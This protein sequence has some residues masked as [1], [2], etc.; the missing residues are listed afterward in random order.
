MPFFYVIFIVRPQIFNN[1]SRFIAG[2]AIILFITFIHTQ[3]A[4]AQYAGGDG[5]SDRPFLI[6]S[7]A[8]LNTIGTDPNNWDKH[9]ILTN[10]IDLTDVSFNVIGNNINR[11]IGVFDGNGK[12]ISH[13]THN[14][15]GMNYVGIFGYVYGSSSLIKDVG[16]IDPNLDAG[17]GSSVGA[18]VGRLAGGTLSGCYV[19]GGQVN[20]YDNVGGLVGYNKASISQSY[21]TAAVTGHN[22]IGGLL[23]YNY[24]GTVLQCWSTSLIEGNDNVGGLVGYNFS[25]DS[26]A[27]INQSYAAGT[28]SSTGSN[29]GGLAGFS[30]F[31]RVINCYS[32]TEV[33]GN[34]AVGGLVG[35]NYYSE[36]SN[37]FSA[38]EVAGNTDSGG[39]IGKTDNGTVGHSFWDTT[40]A[41][42]PSSA[43][44]VGKSTTQMHTETT[45]T[46]ESW[47]FV[48]ENANGT[49]DI[50]T[51]YDGVTYP[52]L[53]WQ[54]AAGDFTLDSEIN[55]D[56][57]AILAAAWLIVEGETSWNG[58]CDLQKNGV[59][60][61]AD[62]EIFMQN[63]LSTTP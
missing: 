61:L 44:G 49:D 57:F 2:F 40:A 54:F 26:S 8:Q 18:L 41:G 3:S 47:D 23:G 52:G 25:I 19:N 46:A 62:L 51:I 21:S 45:F 31:S 36:V 32:L 42:Q 12:T 10:N 22:N 11:F 43:G 53:A 39:L 7:P 63:Y 5:S 55:I 14:S 28:V 29:S 6:A 27:T 17:S 34:D 50:W 15:T 20:G 58:K 38:G 16:L 4:F 60:D 1:K 30:N 59:I 33:N 24:F 48:G 35:Y 9:F 37:S 56:D 13:F